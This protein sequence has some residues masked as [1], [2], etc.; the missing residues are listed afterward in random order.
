MSPPS[1]IFLFLSFWRRPIKNAYFVKLLQGDISIPDGYFNSRGRGGCRKSVQTR[2]AS[3]L[4]TS[5]CL[6]VGP[7]QSASE[8]FLCPY[9]EP[10]FPY[11]LLKNRSRSE[12]VLQGGLPAS[13]GQILKHLMNF[14]QTVPFAADKEQLFSE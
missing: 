4:S 2:S 13:R 3:T 7:S 14:W 1:L 8:N 12:D 5:A 6:S 11:I 9:L 10:T